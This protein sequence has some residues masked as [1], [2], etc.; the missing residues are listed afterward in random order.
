M[1]STL[2]CSSDQQKSVWGDP[3][4][5]YVVEG[6]RGSLDPGQFEE[7]TGSGLIS[8]WPMKRGF[9]FPQQEPLDDAAGVRT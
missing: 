9:F 2:H 3:C 5:V 7:R 4:A 1:L 6:L 8:S